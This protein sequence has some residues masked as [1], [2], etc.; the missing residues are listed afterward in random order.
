[1]SDIGGHVRAFDMAT[2]RV[3]WTFSTSGPV[4]H[5]PALAER[6]AV[7]RR[8]RGRHVLHRRRRPGKLVWRHATHGLA[9]GFRSGSFYSTPAVAYGR[10]YIGNTDG[11]VYA[12]EASDG[13][14]AW[15]YTMPYWAY[16]SPGVARR[17]R[18][19]DVV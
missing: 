12:F 2:G 4:K 16:G 1:M 8:L 9:S 5:G 19:R 14:I 17:A 3:L 15:T 6:P 18:L 7:L 11:K 13:Q 10:V